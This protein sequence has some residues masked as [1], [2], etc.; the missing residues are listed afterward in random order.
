MFGSITCN[1]FWSDTSKA[2]AS[3]CFTALGRP[4][5]LFRLLRHRLSATSPAEFRSDSQ[6]SPS[7]GG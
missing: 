3:G 7:T 5:F 1:I 6:P 4:V 2:T